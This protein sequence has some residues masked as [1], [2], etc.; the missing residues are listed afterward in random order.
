MILIIILVLALAFG[1]F[2]FIKKK[3]KSNVEKDI[4]QFNKFEDEE[5]AKPMNDKKVY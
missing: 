1:L 2:Y 4:N 3:Y 5:D